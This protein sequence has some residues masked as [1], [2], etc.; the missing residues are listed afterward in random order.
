MVKNRNSIGLYYAADLDNHIKKHSYLDNIGSLESERWDLHVCY[1]GSR[2][3]LKIM[4]IYIV[5]RKL[6]F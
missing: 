2:D 5:Y 1:S 4:K 3:L 6:K